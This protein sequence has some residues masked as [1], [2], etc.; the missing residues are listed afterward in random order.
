V[1]EPWFPHVKLGVTGSSPVPPIPNV[2][3]AANGFPSL[4]R[5]PLLTVGLFRRSRPLSELTRLPPGEPFSR[6]E[7]RALIAAAL[8][9]PPLNDARKLCEQAPSSSAL[10]IEYERAEKAHSR[11]LIANFLAPE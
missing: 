5:Y 11:Q 6:G 1:G 8:A 7:R 2:R 10:G 9:S 3:S 4:T